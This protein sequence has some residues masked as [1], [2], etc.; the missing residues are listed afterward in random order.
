MTTDELVA[1]E[2]AVIAQAP[3]GA[4][5]V[6]ASVSPDGTYGAALTLLPTAGDYLMDDVFIRVGHE[7]EA[8]S[9]GSAG[10]RWTSLDDESETGVLRYA[11][12]ASAETSA[13]WIRYEGEDY[14]VPVRH[15]HFLFVAWRT[16]FHEDPSVIRFE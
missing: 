3:R 4:V 9:G 2:K 7:W 1:F 13:A 12:E 5:V 14:R 6:G 15:G 8:Y 10:I 11:D 16:R